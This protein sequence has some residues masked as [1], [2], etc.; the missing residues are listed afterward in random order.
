APRLGPLA[1]ALAC[2]TL[3]CGGVLPRRW[4]TRHGWRMAAR[5]FAHRLR[6][7]RLSYFVAGG[8]L[9]GAVAIALVAARGSM[10]SW[11]ALLTA[12][13]GI[14]AAGGMIW[15]VRGVG[16]AALRRE[17]VGFGA[18]MLMSRVGTCIGWQGALIVFF[19]APF[20]GLVNGLLQWTMHREPEIPY[21]P[22]L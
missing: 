1:I 20:L 14:A 7:E 11:A 9:V 16:S 12:L 13:V 18:V 5:V 22:Y 15:I 3:W 10:A 19:L 17:A 8:W 4:N 6:V 2:W 21:G